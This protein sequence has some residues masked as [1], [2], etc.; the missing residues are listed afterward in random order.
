M[1]PVIHTEADFDRLSWHDCHLWGI[2]F[3]VG[4]P[5]QNDWT[6]DLELDIDFIVEWICGDDGRCRFRVA[7]AT[8]VFHEV[9]DPTIQLDWG[10][11]DFRVALHLASIDDIERSVVPNQNVRLDRSYD[12]WTI[13]F[14]WPKGSKVTFGAAGFTQSL[15]TEPVLT[16]EQSLSFAQRSGRLNSADEPPHQRPI[17]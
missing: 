15:R 17:N 2:Q 12:R 10:N 14:N 4:N 16:S 3:R 9:T 7:P 5:A 6:S 8:L 1:Y 13:R 11:S